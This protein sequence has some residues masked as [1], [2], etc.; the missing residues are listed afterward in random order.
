M[1]LLDNGTQINTITPNFVKSCS[2]EVGPLSDLVGRWVTCVGLGNALTWPVGY[3]IIWIQVDGVQGYDEDQI[4]LVISDLSNFVALVPII[5]GTLMIS[6][7][8]NV[9]KEK[10][11]DALVMPWVNAQVAYLLTVWWATGTI[12]DGKVVAGKSYPSEYDEIIT[13]KDAKTTDAFS[14]HVIHVRMRIAHTGEGINVMAQALHA[15]DGSLPQGL[16]IQNAY[17]ELCS[18]S[19]NVTVVVRNSMAYP[20]TLRKK[21]P[22][23]R[24]VRVTWVLE[25]PVHTDRMETSE[26]AH[27][28]QAPKHT[29]KQRQEKL[30]EEI[31]S[32][33]IGILATWAG[34]FCP[35]SLGW[36][37]WCLLPRTQQTWLYPFNQTCD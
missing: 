10:E 24:A 34:G 9:I 13:T 25:L 26:E 32:E 35:V 21:T 11:I 23:A 1:A 2:L 36:I 17:T 19:R 7:I 22:V 20:Q 18:G 14:S 29:M 15:E 5:L 30:F 4:A 28:P 3:V 6:P 16:T 12:E 33:W 8:I 37:P 27:G 31:R